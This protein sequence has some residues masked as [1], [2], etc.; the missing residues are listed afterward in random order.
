MQRTH[1]VSFW[2]EA[3][4]LSACY[5]T[6]SERKRRCK[7][8]RKVGSVRLHPSEKGPAQSQVLPTALCAHNLISVFWQGKDLHKLLDANVCFFFF[9]FAG[10][11][12]NCRASSRAWWEEPRRGRCLE[13]KSRI[14]RGKPE[15]LLGSCN[16]LSMWYVC[17]V[18]FFTDMLKCVPRVCTFWCG[19][20]FLIDWRRNQFVLKLFLLCKLK[21]CL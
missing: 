16:G 13:G 9:M 15:K 5:V 7:E 17:V 20:V 14:E 6:L 18:F 1:C 21:K 10:N 2:L 3:I 11:V 8:K 12:P 4:N 19:C